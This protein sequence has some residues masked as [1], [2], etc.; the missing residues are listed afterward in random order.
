MRQ[1][2]PNPSPNPTPSPPSQVCDEASYLSATNVIDGREVGCGKSP[3]SLLQ[4]SLL[5]TGGGWRSFVDGTQ[6]DR[7]MHDGSLLSGVTSAIQLGGKVL[8]GSATHLAFCSAMCRTPCVN[9]LNKRLPRLRD[10][11]K[12]GWPK[13]LAKTEKN[14]GKAEGAPSEERTTP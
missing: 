10:L 1:A 13:M 12:T 14:T 11:L 7:L 9:T 8:M 5:G 6:S 2:N 4:I 3:G